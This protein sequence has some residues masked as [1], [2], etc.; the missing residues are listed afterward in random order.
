MKIKANNIEISWELSGIQN[1]E[2]VV[3]S[4]S[5]GSSGIMWKPQLPVLETE[6]NVLRIDTSLD[7][8]LRS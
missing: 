4:H 1:E 3:L 8:R 2:T 7:S 6:F 5:F